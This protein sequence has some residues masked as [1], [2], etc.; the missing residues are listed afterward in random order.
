MHKKRVAAVG[1][2]VALATAGLGF[3]A[4]GVASAAS[5]SCSKHIGNTVGTIT[6]TTTGG[7]VTFSDVWADCAGQS[8]PHHGQ[9]TINGTSTQ[10]FECTFDIWNIYTK[11]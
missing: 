10:R 11:F 6:C 9:W 8:D 2:T 3:V 5:V 7:A 1:V 4:P